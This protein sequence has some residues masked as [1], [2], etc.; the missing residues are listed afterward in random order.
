M[1][2][3]PPSYLVTTYED[4][5]SSISQAEMVQ[6]ILH[7]NCLFLTYVSVFSC[8]HCTI[9]VF[10]FCPNELILSCPPLFLS[11]FLIPCFAIPLVLPVSNGGSSGQIGW[12]NPCFEEPCSGLH[13]QSAQW[14]AQPAGTGSEWAN[15]SHRTKLS[16]LVTSSKSDCNNGMRT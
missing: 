2:L 4:G 1:G 11:L 3:L 15:N 7:L 8:Q 14:L 13:R 12:C 16:C 6:F 9:T 5:F 10:S